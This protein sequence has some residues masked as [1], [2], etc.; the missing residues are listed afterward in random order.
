MPCREKISWLLPFQHLTSQG[1]AVKRPP[2]MCLQ[3]LLDLAIESGGTHSFWLRFP[4]SPR[5]KNKA[6][7]ATK[8]PVPAPRQPGPGVPTAPE[9]VMLWLMTAE[10]I[11]ACCARTARTRRT[12]CCAS[13]RAGATLRLGSRSANAFSIRRAF[14]SLDSEGGRHER[15]NTTIRSRAAH[16][17]CAEFRCA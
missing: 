9:S 4:R 2:S 11:A 14:L 6:Q 10:R 7:G 15:H 3:T 12:S 16:D 17:A 8:P 13:H 1:R 5:T